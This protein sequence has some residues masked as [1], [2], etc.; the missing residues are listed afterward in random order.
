[1]VWDSHAYAELIAV[2]KQPPP[3]AVLH[4]AMVHGAMYDAVNSVA[5]GHQPYLAD[6]TA[7]PTASIDAAAATAAHDV[8]VSLLPGRAEQLDAL[9]ELSLDAVPDGPAE[10]S[11]MAVGSAAADAM[12]AARANDGRS[13]G[14]PLFSVGADPGDWR[15]APAGNSFGW[16]AEVKPFL[17]EHPSDFATPGPLPL[18]SP[19]YAAELDEVQRLGSKTSAERTADQTQM[20]LFWSDHTTAIWSRI[21]H[22]VAA[23]Q[24]LTTEA[25]ARYFAAAYMSGADAVIACFDDKERHGFWRPMTAI[26][27]AASD[28][29]AATTAD[30]TWEPLIANP[31]YAFRPV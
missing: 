11:G 20:A 5:G 31:P 21:L 24:Q 8:L 12:L 2:A 15:P 14:D 25:S 13:G 23:G 26:R 27:E 9:H 3:T 10:D 17:I 7:D 1:M 4:L 6:H 18:A 29:N 19:A 30:P 28:G 16:V 22:Q